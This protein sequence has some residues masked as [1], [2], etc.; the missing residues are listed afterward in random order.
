[1]SEKRIIDYLN[2]TNP[3][4]LDH[5]ITFVFDNTDVYEYEEIF[6]YNKNDLV[7]V[8][9]PDTNRYI[10][11]RCDENNVT[12][13]F[14]ET[15]WFEL[16]FERRLT[17]KT[18]YTNKKPT[19]VDHGGILAG[20]TFD[21]VD[22]DTLI[23]N[24]LYPY[25]KPVVT[26]ITPFN[27]VYEKGMVQAAQEIK[28]TIQTRSHKI[29]K[30]ELYENGTLIESEDNP[31]DGTKIYIR[32][33]IFD[34]KKYVLKLTDED[35]I[36]EYN[37]INVYFDH[38]NYYGVCPYKEEPNEEGVKLASKRLV[39]LN[40][41]LS[42]DVPKQEQKMLIFAT[43]NHWGDLK[44]IKDKQGLEYIDCFKIKTI[45]ITC[46]NKESINYKVY[47]SNDISPDVDL[48]FDFI[49]EEA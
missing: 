16:T 23:T 44:S 40:E 25:I 34:N 12:G 26:G 49:F 47:Y 30:L 42:Y 46:V 36:N 3:S 2:S 10:I 5:V 1:M 21:K 19:L 33:N 8:Y 29:T 35:R 24:I 6:T 41:N 7:W 4:L 38:P 20:T 9:N 45:P 48:H 14:D 27:I 11:Y 43:P 22:Y 39:M 18:Q 32:N 37:I 31:S 13:P 28:F 17:E 15:K